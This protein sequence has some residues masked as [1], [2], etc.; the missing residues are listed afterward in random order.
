[1]GCY[2]RQRYTGGAGGSLKVG[3]NERYDACR[4][5]QSRVPSRKVEQSQPHW[6]YKRQSVEPLRK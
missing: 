5:S 1:M 3:L 2:A 6:E 4:W